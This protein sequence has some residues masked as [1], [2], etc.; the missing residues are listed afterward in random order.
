MNKL[1]DFLNYLKGR[2]RRNR[3]LES[4]LFFIYTRFTFTY[5]ILQAKSI[6]SLVK[7]IRWYVL[8]KEIQGIYISNGLTILE[9]ADTRKFYWDP[10]D[11]MSLLGMGLVGEWERDDTEYLKK[12][13]KTGDTVIDVGANYGFHTILF[14]KLTGP[15]G[16]VYAFEPLKS[17]YGQLEENLTLNKSQDNTVLSQYALGNKRGKFKIYVPERMGR[18][19][20]SLSKRGKTAEQEVCDVI[21]LDSYV[22]NKKIK[23]ISFIKC[24]I[25]GAELLAFQGAKNV[26]KNHRP[27]LM[28]EVTRGSSESFGYTPEIL[29][30]F[31]SEYNYRFYYTVKGKLVKIKSS[32]VPY[33]HGNCFALPG[34]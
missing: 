7:V 2:V 6:N 25:E 5:R 13:V 28:V 4:V 29:L 16:K 12:M 22:N 10:E 9:L 3:H 18:G 30:K 20:A 34:S 1:Q 8:K 27:A 23:K 11:R 33:F 19:A 17:M 31:L 24:D 21:T 32:D 15:K 26:L 14:S